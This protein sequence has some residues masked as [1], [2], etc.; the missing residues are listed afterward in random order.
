MPTTF[1]NY[2]PEE[3]SALQ[4]QNDSLTAELATARRDL[5]AATFTY[6]EQVRELG[7]IGQYALAAL[8]AAESSGEVQISAVETAKARVAEKLIGEKRNGIVAHLL[9]TRSEEFADEFGPDWTAQ[10]R[11]RLDEMFK[12]DG[13]Y[14]N[15]RAKAET[16][17]RTEVEA[18]LLATARAAALARH[19]TPEARAQFEADLEKDSDFL[20]QKA[21]VTGE[22]TDNLHAQWRAAVMGGMPARI[23]AELAEQEPKIRKQA[24]QDWRESY[25]GEQ[26]VRQA[27]KRAERKAADMVLAELASLVDEPLLKEHVMQRVQAIAEEQTDAEMQK[28]MLEDFLH[29]SLDSTKIP[30][31]TKVSLY[32]GEVRNVKTR[33]ADLYYPERIEPQVHCTRK[34]ELIARGEGKFMT[35]HDSLSDSDISY[36]QKDAVE[37]G[38]VIVIGRKVVDKSNGTQGMEQYLSTGMELYYDDDTTTENV[39]AAGANIVDLSLNGKRARAGEIS[40]DN[41]VVVTYTTPK[42]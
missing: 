40:D 4:A 14:E 25:E 35:I 9:A 13:T 3:Y 7:E 39:V 15:L 23:E 30:K 41:V 29:G 22:V 33:K 26:Y 27:E 8:T 17:A 16:D 19:D 36:V 1:G 11:S 12:T 2:T 5:N 31:D 10:E 20:R 6:G 37:R 28:G 18:D 38:A 24:E 34:I 42:S 32:L 21:E